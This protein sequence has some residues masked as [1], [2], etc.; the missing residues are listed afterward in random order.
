VVD[1]TN[2]KFVDSLHIGS[3]CD[4]TGFDSNTKN[5]F[6]SN[7]DG[8]LSIYHEVSANKFELVANVPTKRGARTIA[9]NEQKH[10]IYLPTA[11]FETN[12]APQANGQPGRPRMIP[13]TFQILVVGQ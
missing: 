10:L 6:A 8:T 12:P 2:G 13:G 5:V 9:V 4:G 1:A 7:G 3:G 11:D